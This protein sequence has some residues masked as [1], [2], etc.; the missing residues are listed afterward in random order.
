[1]EL[2]RPK[3]FFVAV[4]LLAV[5]GPAAGAP[6]EEATA[7]LTV[8]SAADGMS[9]SLGPTAGAVVHHGTMSKAQIAAAMARMRCGSDAAALAG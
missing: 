5:L 6:A 4:A 7:C 1:M 8:G 3:S 2:F 9:A